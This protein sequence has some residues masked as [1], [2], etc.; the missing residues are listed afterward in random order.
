[1][2]VLVARQSAWNDDALQLATQFGYTTWHIE[3]A[4]QGV[5]F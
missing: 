1:M 5:E 4:L 3:R 2:E